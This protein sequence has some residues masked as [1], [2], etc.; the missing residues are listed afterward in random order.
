[1]GLMGLKLVIVDDAPFIREALKNIVE[2]A[3]HVVIG[4]AQDGFEAVNVVCKLKPDIVL[5]DLVLPNLNGIEAAKQILSECP[6][7]KVIACSTESEKF[8]T[9][10][11]LEVGCISFISKPF[12][13]ADVTERINEAASKK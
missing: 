9:L 13:V 5:M 1:M 8:M 6:S 7:V 10:K 3:G 2:K 4:E 12:Q 11:A